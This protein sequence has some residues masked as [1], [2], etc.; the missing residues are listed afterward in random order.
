MDHDDMRAGDSDRQVVAE[1]L[2][3]ALDEGR[4]DRGEYD[5][6]LRKTYAAK[7]YGDL[8]GL[9]DGLPGVVPSP[10]AR[11]QAYQAP[12]AAPPPAEPRGNGL[13]FMAGGLGIFLLCTLIW[14]LT[15]IGS[16]FYYFWP[17]WTLFPFLLAV[18]A[19]FAGG[20]SRG[21]NR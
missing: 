16:G 7:T 20:G 9:L 18:I 15:S 21:Q 2:K 8:N 4:L 6:R 10:Q 3:T 5:E 14:L 12:A 11:S 17:V 19:R 13:G 1:R